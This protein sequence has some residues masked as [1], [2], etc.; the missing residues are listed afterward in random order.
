MKKFLFVFALFFVVLG[1]QSAPTDAKMMV[2]EEGNIHHIEQQQQL[3]ELSDEERTA[4]ETGKEVPIISYIRSERSDFF[5]II[6]IKGYEE[7]V[8][9]VLSN[10]KLNTIT[11]G[12]EMFGEEEI[13]IHV[14]ACIVAIVFMIAVNTMTHFR[15]LAFALTFTV[16]IA[17]IF[18]VAIAPTFAVTV[19]VVGVT[20]SAFAVARTVVNAGVGAYMTKTEKRVYKISSVI[21][22]IL[23]VI[24]MFI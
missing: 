24:V 5:H 6:K 23:I 7:V 2:D 22:Y 17:L 21:F 13:A 1:A 14:I 4:V 9:V 11:K 10:G 3:R 20:V 15:A 19:T 18:A 16:V 12:G 8:D